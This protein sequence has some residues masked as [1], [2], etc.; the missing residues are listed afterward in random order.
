M[1]HFTHCQLKFLTLKNFSCMNAKFILYSSPG[2][3]Y[4]VL[5]ALP[6]YPDNHTLFRESLLLRTHNRQCP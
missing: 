2:I 3:S 6:T 5:H 4:F 1:N